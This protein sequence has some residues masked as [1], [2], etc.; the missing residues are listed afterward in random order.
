MHAIK[1]LTTNTFNTHDP[2]D[3]ALDAAL[4]AITVSTETVRDR[5]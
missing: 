4:L 5:S 3:G 1:L 2:H